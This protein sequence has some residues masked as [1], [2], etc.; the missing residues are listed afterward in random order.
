[1]IAVK[2]TKEQRK[3][4]RCLDD[5]HSLFFL[6]KCAVVFAGRL[7]VPSLI[8]GCASPQAQSTI[9]WHH[10]FGFLCAQHS[11]EVKQ[12]VPGTKGLLFPESAHQSFF[13][14][15]LCRWKLWLHPWPVVNRVQPASLYSMRSPFRPFKIGKKQRLAQI[16][17]FGTFMWPKV[18]ITRDKMWRRVTENLR[19]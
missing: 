8:D 6:K 14:G 5:V 19:E 13:I 4:R 11:Q 17:D 15:L 9:L 2:Q 10:L 12:A 7:R 1:M 3:R 18:T 16:Q